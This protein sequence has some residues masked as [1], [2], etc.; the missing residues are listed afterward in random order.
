MVFVFPMVD[1]RRPG[2]PNGA[3]GSKMHTYD[4][5]Q[6]EGRLG[7]ACEYRVASE[8]GIRN[9]TKVHGQ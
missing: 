3:D 9:R 6:L 5:P 1:S 8:F 2:R 7:R 4:K